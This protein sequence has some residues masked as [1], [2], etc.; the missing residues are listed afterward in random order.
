MLRR[1]KPRETGALGKV[2]K[3]KSFVV[4]LVRRRN[5]ARAL[6]Q[7]KGCGVGGLGGFND[8]FVFAGVFV[9]PE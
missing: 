9:G 8:G 4:K 5:G 2:L 1:G 3:Q 6:Q 7:I